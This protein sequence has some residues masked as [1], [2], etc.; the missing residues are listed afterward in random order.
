MHEIKLYLKLYISLL[1][2]L[3]TFSDR[4]CDRKL[5]RKLN[6]K[7][8]FLI[9]KRNELQQYSSTDIKSDIQPKISYY[10]KLYSQ[11]YI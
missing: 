3:F 2:S 10:P 6:L 9:L 5:H 11:W 7:N 8:Y 1:A 4:D